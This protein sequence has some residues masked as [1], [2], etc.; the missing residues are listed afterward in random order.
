MTKPVSVIAREEKEGWWVWSPQCPGLV[1]GGETEAG[2]LRSLPGTIAYYFE[3][4]HPGEDFEIVV[5]A[6]REVGGVFI[7]VA[8]DEQ[9]TARQKVADRIVAALADPALAQLLRNA[10]AGQFDEVVYICALPTDT[11]AWLDDQLEERRGAVNVVVPLS[12][13]VLWIRAYGGQPFDAPAHPEFPAN[14][15]SP[16]RPAAFGNAT[17]TFADAT[18]TP[19]RQRILVP[20]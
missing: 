7:R 6:E 18:R 4:D 3:D 15:A 17:A 2:L 20:A 14:T 1:T 13:A 19:D 9:H 12:P 8:R 10:P 16:L 5:H 11:R